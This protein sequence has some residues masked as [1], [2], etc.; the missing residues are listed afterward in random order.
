MRGSITE[1]PN[2]IN[3]LIIMTVTPTIVHTNLPN[4]SGGIVVCNYISGAGVN[5]SEWIL[6]GE[7][8]HADI[9]R[10]HDFQI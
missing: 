9:D 4:S 5:I 7:A 2:S 3:A 1:T 10:I 6:T 8:P